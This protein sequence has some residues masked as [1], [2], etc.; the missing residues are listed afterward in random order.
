MS[1]NGVVNRSVNLLV[2]GIISLVAVITGI[3]L[4]FYTYDTMKAITVVIGIAALFVAIRSLMISKEID[5]P[6]LK[7]SM[8]V[9][10]LISIAV[11]VMMIV[12]PSLL[13]N[14]NKYIWYFVIYLAAFVLI[15]SGVLAI[16]QAILF[17]SEWWKSSLIFEGLLSLVAG[18]ALLPDVMTR[19][20]GDFILKLFGIALVVLGVCYFI[21]NFNRRYDL[22]EI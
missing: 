13:Y 17:K 11:A 6:S 3:L 19:F 1:R 21:S 9:R 22:K 12:F 18:L 5:D 2:A 4:L 15:S 8:K 10:A 16:A 14:V 7:S 20:L